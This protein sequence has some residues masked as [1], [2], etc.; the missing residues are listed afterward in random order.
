MF[1]S[2][3]TTLFPSNSS[4]SPPAN[5]L[6]PQSAQLPPHRR[7]SSTISQSQSRPRSFQNNQ[8][9]RP[10]CTWSAHTPQSGPS[11]SPFP[12]YC[13]ALTATATAASE[14]FLF[15]GYVHGSASNDLYVFSTRDLSTTLLQTSGKVPSPRVAHG[16]ALTST[17]F[18]IWGGTTNFGDQNVLNQRLDDSLYFLNLGMSYLFMSRST[19][20]DQSFLC[21]SIA[22]VDSRCGQ[23]SWSQRSLLPY[24]DVG[25][26]QARH[27][28]W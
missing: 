7:T 10:V 22:R 20:A 6:P 1:L 23:W 14:L 21:S 3:L 11:P 17:N 16:A 19:L 18:L 13:H 12:R 28:W 8:Q 15:G 25:R 26:F 5:E 4:G 24:R 9:S 2:S 27:L